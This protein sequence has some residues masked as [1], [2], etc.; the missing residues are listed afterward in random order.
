[1]DQ[2]IIANFKKPYT[3]E[4]FQKCFRMVSDTDLTLTEFWKEH[5]NILSCVGL[6][7]KSWAN[8]SQRTL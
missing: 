7:Q 5:Y 3:K 6:I 4:L 1:M 2:Q 8:V